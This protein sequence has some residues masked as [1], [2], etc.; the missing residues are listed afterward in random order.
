MD[1]FLDAD[2]QMTLRVHAF[3]Y[4]SLHNTSSPSFRPLKSTTLRILTSVTELSDWVVRSFLP[5]LA[6]ECF[7]IA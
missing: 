3:A 2:G 6:R 7:T 1:V 5:F 4:P